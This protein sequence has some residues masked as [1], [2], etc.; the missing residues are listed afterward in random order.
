MTR[1]LN[2]IEYVALANLQEYTE[3]SA[4]SLVLDVRCRIPDKLSNT[5]FYRTMGRLEDEKLARSHF[6]R[7][8]AQNG[9]C[10]ELVFVITEA[11]IEAWQETRHFYDQLFPQFMRKDAGRP[12]GR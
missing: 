4:S 3:T 11:G 5:T 10:K 2:P 9:T 7:I 1:I 6:R 8:A 12:K